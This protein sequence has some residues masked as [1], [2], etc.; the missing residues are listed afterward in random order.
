MKKLI[1][2]LL[3]LPMIVFG[4]QVTQQSKTPASGVNAGNQYFGYW[5]IAANGYFIPPYGANATLNR[6]ADIN[7][8]F[9]VQL[10]DSSIRF[11]YNGSWIP[12]GKGGSSGAIYFNS[13]YFNGLGTAVSPIGIIQSSLFPSQTGNAGK[14][15]STDG[16]G[17]LSWISGGGTNIYNSDGT[18]TGNRVLSGSGYTLRFNNLSYLQQQIFGTDG[19]GTEEAF[20]GFS[21]INNA[22]TFSYGA[23]D[24]YAFQSNE[25]GAGNSTMAINHGQGISYEQIGFDN[26]NTGI[27]VTD[28]LGHYGL[29]TDASVDTSKMGTSNATY[30]TSGW[31]KGRLHS[32]PG[33]GTT[34]NALTNGYGIQT[35]TFNG[36]TSGITVKADTTSSTGLVS[37]SRLATNLG[38]YVK[39]IGVTTANGVSGTSSGGQTPSLTITLGNITPT[40]ISTTIKPATV[41]QTATGT[42]GT[43]SVMVKHS[44]G[45]VDAISATYYATTSSLPT[46]ANPTA[47]AGA[48]AV[49]GS[50]T[51]FMRSDAA[52]K[53]D[54][55]VF[56]TVANFFPK[57]DTRY[58]KSSVFNSLT[59]YSVPIST[60]SGITQDNSNFYYNYSTHQLSVGTNGDFTGTNA[61]NIYG[62]LDAYEPQSSIGGVTSGTAYPGVTAST[63][64]GTGASPSV[65]SSGDNAGGFSGWIYTG[66]T[67]G[68]I[69]AAGMSISA[70]G[71]TNSLG[72]QLDFYTKADGSTTTPSA[73]TITNAGVVKINGLTTNGIVQTSGSNGTLGVSNTLPSTI[74][75]TT[76]VPGDNSTL[77]ATDSY[78]DR[79][80]KVNTGIAYYTYG[81]S[82]T[83]G[84]GATTAANGYSSVMSPFLNLAQTNYA[85]S[86]IGMWNI[87]GQN[88]TNESTTSVVFSSVMGG[89]N[90]LRRGGSSS[91]TLNKIL[92]GYSD[93]FV[94]HF[95]DTLTAAGA[96]TA[97]IVQ[98][99]T[100]SNTYN[101]VTTAGGKTTTAASTTANGATITYYSYGP[102]VEIGLI[103]TD[104]T[105]NTYGTATITIDGTSY[106]TI[107]EN[108]Q[109]DGITDG[110]GNNNSLMPFVKIYTGLGEGKHTVVLTTTSTTQF[111]VDY[112]AELKRPTNSTPL[113]IYQ[114]PVMNATGYTISPANSSNA[115][116]AATN[117]ALISLIASWPQGYPVYTANT[118]AYY[119]AA[120]GQTYSD[121][122]HPNDYGYRLIYQAGYTILV[123][124]QRNNVMPQ[125]LYTTSTPTFA[126]LSL[127]GLTQAGIPYITTGNQFA[128]VATDFNYSSNTAGYVGLGVSGVSADSKL[129][130]LGGSG[131]G[132]RIDYN[133][134]GN[135]YIDG[136][137][138]Y[139]RTASGGA[140]A[141]FTSSAATFSENILPVTGG[142]YNIGG[143][144][145]TFLNGYF[146]Q[147]TANG[148][149]ASSFTPSIT[150]SGSLAK[151]TSFTPTLTTVANGDVLIGADFAPT[152]SGVGT[153]ATLG[154]V[155]GGSSYTN[156]TYTSV[157]LTGG[158]GSGAVAT[159]VVSGGAVSTVTITTAGTR[160]IVGDVLSAAAANIG[161]TGSGFSVPV[162]TLTQLATG[163]VLRA[164][165]NNIGQGSGSSGSWSDGL[166]M[167][168][169]T[170][171]TATLTQNAPGIHFSSYG[172]NTGSSAS[173]VFDSYIVS[174]AQTGAT[175]PGGNIGFIFYQNGTK[176]G[177]TYAFAPSLASFTGVQLQ[178]THSS[179][180]STVYTSLALL[181]GTAATSGT[182]NQWTNQYYQEGAVWNTGGT[183]ASNSFAFG[184]IGE[185]TSSANPYA[186]WYFQTYLGTSTTPT[187]VNMASFTT[188][189][190]FNLALDN[191]NVQAGSQA[192]TIFNIAASTVTD[193][194][195][196]SG[197]VTNFAVIGTGLTTLAATNA[198][199]TYTN[200]YG[201][202]FT[203]P[204]NGTNVTMTNKYALGLA[205]DATHLFTVA[206][207][208]SGAATLNATSTVTITPATTIT[209]ALTASSTINKVTVTAP[210]TSATL[211]LVTGSTL[212]TTGAFTLNLTTT[213]NS[214]PTFPSGSGTVPYL[215]G[216]NTW[217]GVN[218]MILKNY[219]ANSSPTAVNASATLTAAQVQSSITTT[220]TT[221][222][223]F[224]MPTATLLATQVG[225]AQGTI[226]FFTI[227]NSASTASGAITLTLGSGMTSGLTAGLTVPIGKAQTYEIYFT[228]TTTCVMSQIL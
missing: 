225:A 207:N 48:T 168:N 110:G 180:G 125:K 171:A 205:Y 88:F 54:S 146:N 215:S 220:S 200:G 191:S 18:L 96:S 63:S 91:L 166:L 25:D 115:I 199:I 38:G 28:Q 71:V 108:G 160:Y 5:G 148:T 137:T 135:D 65:N 90:D 66:G 29:V 53:V 163:S 14:V 202:F 176:N 195:T 142:T 206:V 74:T 116:V 93:I 178:L 222:V 52:P 156:G 122:I 17:N 181:N 99:G 100:W 211:T 8:L 154:T 112:F 61:I 21:G 26:N 6:A 86:G 183:P 144:G 47:T 15:L 175:S 107:N 150:A 128:T 34:T 51:T 22:I 224:T 12:I 16:S 192:G 41:Y 184:L 149:V 219:Q 177:S 167:L 179:Q 13:T 82:F 189:G 11:R 190:Q 67:P 2:L 81:D 145:Q 45:I 213:A 161:G 59:Q 3:F 153:I 58:L 133:G 73:M 117:A 102:D 147:I 98:T 104:G 60:G 39:T 83:T 36:G 131:A 198:S 210:A 172:W 1:F 208:S 196:A 173:Q 95:A 111:V 109:T 158:T 56:Q 68:Y 126:G 186:S 80:I 55:T 40:T 216:T 185:G 197:T 84:T 124:L 134:A 204:T 159:V 209:G 139:F 30:V 33:G 136:T 201:A 113:L 121:N 228:S 162:A 35:F 164:T 10:S 46:S 226:I 105:I 130:V 182:P 138:I 188:Q 114:I 77:I 37:K 118:G 123:G 174:S 101:A 23:G 79:P 132:L 7:G 119:T 141:N 44:G 193:N 223:A 194:S 75:A 140:I 57:G 157:P 218:T 212:Q 78:V 92:N 69:Y 103:G 187:F 4:Q 50:A 120:S 64:R 42:A 214:T 24:Q 70:Q 94:N 97:R 20:I 72:G 85:V 203:Q 49:N 32:L 9:Y 31:V 76:Q 221:A 169:S 143:A 19:L 170:A 165:V 217:T 227:D 27:K 106:G 151:G 89:F 43:D 87:A 129:R 127:T 155:T 152:L 62:Q